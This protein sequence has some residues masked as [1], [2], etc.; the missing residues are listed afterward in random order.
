ML[1]AIDADGARRSG[2]HSDTNS[3]SKKTGGSVLDVERGWCGSALRVL[4][5]L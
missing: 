1:R 2:S 4:Q 3:E 5:R